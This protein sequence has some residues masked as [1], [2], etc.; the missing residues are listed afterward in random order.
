MHMTMNEIVVP[1]NSYRSPNNVNTF[2]SNY[3]KLTR[4]LLLTHE[5]R[6]STYTGNSFPKS[7]MQ[8]TVQRTCQHFG[9]K[10]ILPR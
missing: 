3:S 7:H 5:T 10:K 8:K 6:Q 2:C 1:L 9:A 4:L